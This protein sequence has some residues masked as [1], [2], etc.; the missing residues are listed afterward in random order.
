MLLTRMAYIAN[1]L[2]LFIY[3]LHTIHLY[4]WLF[5]G[6]NSNLEPCSRGHESSHQVL[7]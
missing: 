3:F 7:C 2:Y 5:Y 6:N 4:C 1:I